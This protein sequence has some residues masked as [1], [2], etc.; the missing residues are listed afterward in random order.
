M[1]EASSFFEAHDS[2]IDY[3]DAAQMIEDTVSEIDGFPRYYDEF[4]AFL[5]TYPSRS[6]LVNW[7]KS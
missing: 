7:L 2:F 4:V 5:R 1:K 6:A 3:D